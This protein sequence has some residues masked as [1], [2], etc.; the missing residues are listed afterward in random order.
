MIAMS[1]S[2]DFQDATHFTVGTVG[3]P[4]SRV[5]YL[6]VGDAYDIVSLK[7][8]KQQVWA[9]AQFLEGVLADL[10][11]TDD[12]PRT[13]AFLKP[14][15]PDWIVGQI[16]VGVDDSDDGSQLVLVIEEL[17]P[18]SELDDDD[19]DDDELDDDLDD[20][21]DESDDVDAV[22]EALLG[23]DDSAGANVR[24]RISIGQAAAFVAASTELMNQGRPPCRL[25]G[26]PL[27]PSGHFCPRLN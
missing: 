2:Y 23:V 25:C 11:A 16:A 19:F 5:F 26:Q 15:H 6:Q 10:P 1:Q 3:E 12:T 22:V 4:G 14:P 8:E 17:V 7:L 9:L 20:D 13:P 24:A 21:F 18:G 27:D